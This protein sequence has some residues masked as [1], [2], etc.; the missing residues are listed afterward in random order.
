MVR[1]LQTTIENPV[2]RQEIKGGASVRANGYSHAI[3]AQ[4]TDI[5]ES[6]VQLKTPS[7]LLPGTEVYVLLNLAGFVVEVPGIVRAGDP[8]TGM[9][10]G[11]SKM[12]ACTQEKLVMALRSL[13][14]PELRADAEPARTS[15]LNEGIKLAM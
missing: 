2:K 4:I 12:S 10:I 14:Q 15:M 6:G 8:Q 11:F 5:S 3:Y 7:M 13:H 9:Q 1:S